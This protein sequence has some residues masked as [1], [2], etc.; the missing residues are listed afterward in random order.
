VASN[1][2]CKKG[3][4]PGTSSSVLAYPIPESDMRAYLANLKPNAL[5]VLALSAVAIAYPVV[6]ILLPAVLRAIV[7]DA[8]RSVLNLI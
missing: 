6:T 4:I 8:V 2:L 7:P 5:M 1:V 3:Q